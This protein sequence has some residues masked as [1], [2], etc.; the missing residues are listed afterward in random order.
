[1][2]P[3]IQTIQG[4]QTSESL[5]VD[6]RG[7][8]HQDCEVLFHVNKQSPDIAGGVRVDRDD[9][10]AGNGDLWWSCS[11]GEAQV[12]DV[13][14]VTRTAAQHRS[15]Q[16]HK[17]EQRTE[18][19]T[20]EGERDQGEE[21]EKGQE[22]RERSERG[23]KE[24][25]RDVEEEEC[26]QVKKDV[27]GWTVVTRSK[28]H[29]KRTVQIFVKVDGGKTSAME[30]EM[31]DKVDDIVK[32]IPISDQDVYVTRGGRIPRRSD[33][34]E[35]CEVR[36]GSTIQVMSR[37]RGGGK[38]KD[39]KSKV[40]KK[41]AESAKTPEQKFTDEEEGDRG[42]AILESEKEAIIRKWEENDVSRK[43]IDVIPEGS[44]K[45]CVARA[46]RIM[47]KAHR[48]AETCERGPEGPRCSCSKMCAR[49]KPDRWDVFPQIT[50]ICPHVFRSMLC[51]TVN[52]PLK[53]QVY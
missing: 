52:R 42:P 41:Q 48:A 9:L 39:K 3:E 18:P 22:E 27:T 35:S 7:L 34:L 51:S 31:S 28:K 43:L 20:Q 6:S 19:A 32:K 40:D 21:G 37:M 10:H 36:D 44:D 2:I 45:V 47:L 12:T 53:P 17:Q 4:P 49:Q 23:K 16:K 26:E 24:E 38:H 33:K 14:V 13:P 50:F 5:S 25:G 15:T 46:S 29:R 8:S 1:M 30:M 11:D